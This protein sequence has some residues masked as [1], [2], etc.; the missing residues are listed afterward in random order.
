M[1]N[2]VTATIMVAAVAVQTVGAYKEVQ[3]ANAAA[4]YNAKLMERNA[5]TAEMQA[6]DA[7]QRG[8]I[9]EKQH[10]LQVSQLKGQQRASFGAS[11][12]L[13]D[14]GST[15]DTLFDTA[16][17]GELD[18]LAIRANAKKEAWNYKNE[19]QN[20]RGQAEL[21]TMSKRNAG[22]AAATT[23]LTGA[24]SMAGTYAAS[25]GK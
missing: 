24:S 17:Y 15:A 11:G 6:T 4:D 3:A 23:L 8:A 21:S 25:K 16:A 2:P 18:A 1:C 9:E 22:F 19:A 13:V 10:R 5:Q 14:S 12:V 7:E 20:Y